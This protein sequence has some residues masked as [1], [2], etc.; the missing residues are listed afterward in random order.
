M[1]NQQEHE[2][3]TNSAEREEQEDKNGS[4]NKK[5]EHCS[6]GNVATRRSNSIALVHHSGRLIVDNFAILVP[7]PR[8]LI[9]FKLGWSIR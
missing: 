7:F 1:I 3:H 5:E 6:L 2:D 8:A 4:K 9:F